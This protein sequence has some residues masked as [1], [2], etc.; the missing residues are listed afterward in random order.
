M[1]AGGVIGGISAGL[2][3]PHVFSW[4]AEYPILLALAVL[5]RPG[6][7][8]PTDRRLR[9]ALDGGLAAALILL[10]I[11]N[12]RP[13]VLDTTTFNWTAAALLGACVLAS[14]AP[15]PFAAIVASPCSPIMP[16]SSG[17]GATFVRSFF[18]VAEVR[19]LPTASFVCCNTAP[20]CMAVNASARP[21]A[22]RSAGRPSCCSIT[23]MARP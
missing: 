10:F 18:G 8:L 6:L 16:S 13:V 11:S 1:S 17:R 2:I 21:T 9:Y 23:G 4:V 19:K 3:A 14:R 5:C 15:L 7:A 12:D 22:D 20:R